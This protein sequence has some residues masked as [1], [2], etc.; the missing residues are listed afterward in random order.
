MNNLFNFTP[1]AKFTMCVIL[2]VRVIEIGSIRRKLYISILVWLNVSSP[3]TSVF[4]SSFTIL[5]FG[6]LSG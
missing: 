6:H 3:G 2:I 4:I 1:N 5:S